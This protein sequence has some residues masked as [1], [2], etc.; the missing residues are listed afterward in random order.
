[1]VWNHQLMNH[2][3]CIC[4]YSWNSWWLLKDVCEVGFLTQLG[5]V[6]LWE[7]LRG[8]FI[9]PSQQTVQ[10]PMPHHKVLTTSGSYWKERFSCWW[11][12]FPLLLCNTP[13]REGLKCNIMESNQN[14]SE[15]EIH[16]QYKVYKGYKRKLNKIQN[17]KG[18]TN[19][20]SPNTIY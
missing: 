1:M 14:T 9:S 6:V 12:L 4:S 2:R 19:E 17:T 20:L 16:Y 15:T 13:T 5:F 11:V 7:P 18:N 8:S 3:K 10:I